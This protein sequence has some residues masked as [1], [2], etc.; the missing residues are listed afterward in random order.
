MTRMHRHGSSSI[1]R[2]QA[3]EILDS[4]GNPTVEVEV[5]LA[6]GAR[7]VAKVPSGASTGSKEALE[8]RDGEERF[9]GK[10]VRRAVANVTGPI[11][12]A[13]DGQ[14]A[15]DQRAIDALL[16]DLDGT[17]DKSALGANALLGASLAIA[18]AASDHAGIPFYRYLGGANAHVLP[19]PMMNVLNGG[20]HA[21]NNV[22]FQEFMF[23]PVGAASYGEALRWCAECY[24]ALASVLK[25]RSEA[26]SVGDEGGF[27]PNLDSNEKA[28]ALLLEGIERAGRTPGTEVAIALDPATSEFYKDG[29][30][31][32]A[33]EGRQ[34]S[35]EDMV[36][37]WEDVIDRYPVVSLE[38]GMAEQDW[39]G[40][41]LLNARL[42]TRVQLV[43]DDVFVTNPVQVRKGIEEKVANS[44]LVKPN[45]IGTLTETIDTARLAMGAGWSAVV[46]HR[47]GETEDTTIAD[48][49]VSLGC[50]QI[51][52]GAPARGERVAKY[53]RLLV[54]EEE[55]GQSAEF[56]GGAALSV[57]PAPAASGS[58]GRGS[59]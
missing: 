38:D 32:L 10:G 43:G 6:S 12:E 4:R 26:T 50:G 44:L 24:H 27:A 23:M 39:E 13:V 18:R 1:V 33:G 15:F 7:G 17:P 55:L 14:D 41:K 22:D 21:S 45:Q 42:G 48:L 56:L 47:S 46:S 49:A 36:A 30:Y 37:Y 35:S 29:S 8:L 19:T 59:Q 16:I 20:V 54:I 57:K 25:E 58:P 28:L 31:V 40:W 52:S 11:A 5:R 9:G 53:N 51:K 3:R 2:V 34:L